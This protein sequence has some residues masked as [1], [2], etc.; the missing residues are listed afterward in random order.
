MPIP[1]WRIPMVGS[2]ADGACRAGWETRLVVRDQERTGRW[3]V[4]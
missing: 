1:A 3:L 2:A 4:V